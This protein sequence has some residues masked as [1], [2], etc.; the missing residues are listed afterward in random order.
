MNLKDVQDEI[1]K[2]WGSS[3]YSAEYNARPDAQRDAHHATLHITKA[4]GKL[5]GLLDDLDHATGDAVVPA[6]LDNS[7]I[8]AALADIVICAARV[9]SRWPDIEHID[10]GEAV[11]RRIEA[12]FPPTQIEAPPAPQKRTC[13]MH[14]DC[15]AADDRAH[16]FNGKK[17]AHCNSDDCED[18][19]PK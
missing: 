12:K 8:E 17:A 10:I 2:R 3:E 14:V 5:A 6:L 7:R 15:D 1:N 13:N 16:S 19:F 18:C 4:L 11:R 9:A